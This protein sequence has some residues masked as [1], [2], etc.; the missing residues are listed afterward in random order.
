MGSNSKAIEILKPLLDKSYNNDTIYYLL[1]SNSFSMANHYNTRSRNE[2]LYKSYLKD[3]INYL[4]DAISKN[5]Q[6]YKAYIIKSHAEHNYG[7]YT[8]ALITIKNAINLFPDSM[9]LILMRG[10][11]KDGVGD[12]NDGLKDIN[13]AISSNQL[14]SNDM[15]TAFR[16]RSSIYED[17]MNDKNRAIEDLLSALSF[18]PKN[19]YAYYQLAD[20]YRS[21]GEKSKA[22]ENYRKAADLGVEVAY[23]IISEYCNK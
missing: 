19:S 6:Y 5:P 7:N 10:I 17:Q 23:E 12:W 16:F 14:D 18:D 8:E 11:E 21:I 20:I 3:A 13:T 4:T 22:C 2:L 15:A 9:S 1:G